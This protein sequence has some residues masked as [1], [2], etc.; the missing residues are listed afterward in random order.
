MGPILKLKTQDDGEEN[1]FYV[2][3]KRGNYIQVLEW[4]KVSPV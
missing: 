1:I 3:N 2:I 4:D